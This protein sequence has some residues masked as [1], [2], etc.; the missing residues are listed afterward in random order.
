MVILSKW[1]GGFIRVSQPTLCLRTYEYSLLTSDLLSLFCAQTQ[2]LVL[3]NRLNF[4]RVMAFFFHP[5]NTQQQHRSTDQ[6]P[7]KVLLLYS[8]TAVVHKPAGK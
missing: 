5:P 7:Q 2:Q 6:T 8:L 1:G 3:V 4:A